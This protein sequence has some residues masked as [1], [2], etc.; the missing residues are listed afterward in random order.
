MRSPLT[1][2]TP[3]SG[4]SSPRINFRVT[5]FPNRSHLEETALR[6]GAPRNLHR[7][8]R[9]C[10]R[11]PVRRVLRRSL[12]RRSEHD[13]R[14][15]GTSRISEARG[16]HIRDRSRQPRLRLVS[17]QQW[18]AHGVSIAAD[19]ASLLSL[20]QSS[21][22]SPCS[23]GVSSQWGWV[24]TVMKERATEIATKRCAS[25]RDSR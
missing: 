17:G 10:R 16:Q 11:R 5:D 18:F 24:R 1:E 20:R 21:F 23:R 9:H 15:I 22:V 6:Q 25:M 12:E 7:S 8:A 19:R 3:A 2:I 13:L 14:P 4:L